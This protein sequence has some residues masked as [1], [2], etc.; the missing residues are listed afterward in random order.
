MKTSALPFKNL[1]HHP[2]RTAALTVLVA[3]LSFSLLSGSIVVLSLNSGLKSLENRLGADIIVLPDSARS[4]VNIDN[5]YL[6]GNT[7]YLCR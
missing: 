7:D 6:Q 2:G 3:L 4:K 5:L 1:A